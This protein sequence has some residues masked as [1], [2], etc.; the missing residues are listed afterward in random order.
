MIV[1]NDIIIKKIF[2]K[3]E[4][5]NFLKTKNQRNFKIINILVIIYGMNALIL[6]LMKF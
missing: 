5:E 1:L 6:L 4:L 3:K 2:I